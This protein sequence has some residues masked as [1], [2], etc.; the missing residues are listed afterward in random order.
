MKLARAAAAALAILPAAA[1]F[2]AIFAAPRDAA[3]C[4]GA[5]FMESRPTPRPTPVQEI[6]RAEKALENGQ[7]LVA[8][9]A[10]LG[11]FPRVRAATAGK[12]GL[13]TRALR[14]F[15][16]ALVRSEGA[17]DEKKA[18]VATT[19]DWTRKANLEWAVQALREVDAKRPN[20]PSVKA[21]L[22]E[23]L[24]RLPHGEA[25]A[26]TILGGLDTKDLMGS[27]QAYAAL[28]KLRE[29][30]GD[31]AGA[32]AAVKR[33]EEMT[34]T[35]GVCRPAVAPAAKPKPTIFDSFAAKA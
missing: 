10:V 18:G 14:V 19:A 11:S 27:P 13:E 21:D 35:P 30:K 24:A 20:D 8:T 33:C 4:G 7:S 1:I 9:Q 17:A 2:G 31:A 29:K 6:A 5:I 28:A 12:D 16:L 34:K 26:H 25:E 15:A 3:A 22:G 32:E 23:A